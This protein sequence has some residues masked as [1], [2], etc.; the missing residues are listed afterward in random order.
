M[1]T[2]YPTILKCLPFIGLGLL[3]VKDLAP[4]SDSVE[5]ILNGMAMAVILAFSGTYLWHE[6]RARQAD[7]SSSSATSANDRT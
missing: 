7:Q 6:R 3:L 5:E 2:R 4:V 1:T